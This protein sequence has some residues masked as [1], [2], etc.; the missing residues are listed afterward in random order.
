MNPLIERYIDLLIQDPNSPPPPG[1]DLETAAFVRSLV[2][3]GTVRTPDALRR[4]VWQRSL[5]AAKTAS[6][7]HNQTLTFVPSSNGHQ[8]RRSV[9]EGDDPMAQMTFPAR[10]RVQ[11][12]SSSQRMGVLTLVA[13]VVLVIFGVVLLTSIP[14]GSPMLNAPEGDDPAGSLF[15]SA[16]QTPTAVP[17]ASPL[18]TLVPENPVEIVEYT[19]QSGDTLA[20]ILQQ[21]NIED[22][23]V[24][25]D[26][27]VLNEIARLPAPGTTILI[28]LPTPTPVMRPPS[29][30]EAT[31]LPPT[32]ESPAG[33]ITVTATPIP[34]SGGSGGADAPQV[35]TYVI[36]EGDKFTLLAMQFDTTLRVLAELNPQIDVSSCDLTRLTGGPNCSVEL[37]VGQEINV[38]FYGET[39][40]GPMIGTP[41]PIDPSLATPLMI[42]PEVSTATPF[43]TLAP[44]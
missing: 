21:F 16:T 20:S 44:R 5:D 34:F 6:R 1:M 9:T 30:A 4:R 25:N 28:P 32:I 18:P 38:P 11:S 19:I 2:A 29:N 13:A 39:P 33:V 43:P 17:T 36:Q 22:F 23:A 31:A 24:V 12:A 42:L 15:Q 35:T 14:S 40:T 27:M 3:A 7:A 10:R 37:T 26:I 8:V 41:V